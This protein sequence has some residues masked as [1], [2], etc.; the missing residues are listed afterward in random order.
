MTDNGWHLPPLTTERLHLAP[1]TAN[2]VP[3]LRAHWNHPWVRQHLFVLEKHQWQT[4]RAIWSARDRLVTAT[5]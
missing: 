2:D 5:P 3:A 1:I 4:V